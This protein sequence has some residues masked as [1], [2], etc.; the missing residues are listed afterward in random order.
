MCDG[1]TGAVCDADGAAGGWRR[2]GSGWRRQ[3]VSLRRRSAE[4]QI[5][6][7]VAIKS[8]PAARLTVRP[9]E[10]S[11]QI[12]RF[13]RDDAPDF[14]T[15]FSMMQQ[16]FGFAF[17]YFKLLKHFKLFFVL[18]AH[19]ERS[20]LFAVNA[21]YKSLTYLLAVKFLKYLNKSIWPRN[22]L[23][24]EIVVSTIYTDI[25]FFSLKFSSSEKSPD[26]ASFANR[27]H[28]CD[29]CVRVGEGKGWGSGTPIVSSLCCWKLAQWHCTLYHSFE[30][31]KNYANTWS[32]FGILNA[33]YPPP[34]SRIEILNFWYYSSY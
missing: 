28:W 24:Q 11:T 7:H 27:L 21:L 32:V 2:S 30:R 25:P 6:L 16:Q 4:T 33:V 20:T 3:H 23:S 5:R 19:R 15:S 14:V 22:T 13:V 12:R 34:P 31:L 17:C 9:A 1:W 18:L 10:I 29:Q 8:R 26:E